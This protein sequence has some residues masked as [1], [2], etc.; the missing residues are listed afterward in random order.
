MAKGDGIAEDDEVL[1]GDVEVI[2]DHEDDEEFDDDIDDEE[3]IDDDPEDDEEFADV[4]EPN[5]VAG[6][7]G[8]SARLRSGNPVS[9]SFPFSD[10]FTGLRDRIGLRGIIAIVVGGIVLLMLAFV[11]ITSLFSGSPTQA[12]DSEEVSGTAEAGATQTPSGE[13]AVVLPTDTGVV[14]PTGLPGENT[15]FSA[16]VG[17][18]QPGNGQ[19]IAQYTVA[20]GDNLF[21]I[22][23]RYGITEP[24]GWIIAR[25]NGIS[26]PNA[27][28]V[29][30]VLCIPPV[31]SVQSVVPTLPAMQQIIQ[32]PPLPASCTLT[33]TV[34]QFQ[35]LFEIAGMYGM[36]N[37]F[38]QLAS[39]NGISAP[40]YRIYI[41]QRIC[42]RW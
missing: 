21:R 23:L 16:P 38:D 12:T 31:Q 2:D 28:S 32:Q 41:G 19:C 8:A 1:T 29:G 3:D 37:Q 35:G 7:A 25:A 15:G 26:N 17:T 22:G 24:D 30:Q 33:H 5:I 11:L 6:K 36:Y 10:V 18:P 40:G 42:I 14:P 13:G 9:V 39:V 20:E 34:E 27:I 4:R